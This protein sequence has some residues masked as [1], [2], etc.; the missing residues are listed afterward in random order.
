MDNDDDDAN[1]ITRL[2]MA[3]LSLSLFV[4]Q[5]MMEKAN[6]GRLLILLYKHL[7][8]QENDEKN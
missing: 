6:T 3:S 4:V 1:R 7:L 8:M 2:K 5:M